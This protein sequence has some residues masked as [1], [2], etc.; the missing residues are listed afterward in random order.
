MD[1]IEQKFK[2]ELDELLDRYNFKMYIDFDRLGA[3]GPTEA[4]LCVENIGYDI[5]NISFNLDEFVERPL[6]PY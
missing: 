2:K 1:E 3:C 5:E 4:C 6:C